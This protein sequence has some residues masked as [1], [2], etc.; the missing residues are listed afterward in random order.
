M[1]RL[2]LVDW[3]LWLTVIAFQAVLACWIRFRGHDRR[4]PSL[5]WF[6]TLETLA[7]LLLLGIRL[8]PLRNPNTPYFYTYWIGSAVCAVPEVWII[9]QIGQ[10]VL[11]ASPRFGRWIALGILVA[12]VA[13][14][15]G[16]L[17]LA[18]PAH[19]SF[20]WAITNLVVEIHRATQLAWLATFLTVAFVCDFLGLGWRRHA[21][22][23]SIGFCIQACGEALAGWMLGTIG[24]VNLISNINELIYVL[25]L[26]TWGFT[27][28]TSEPIEISEADASEIHSTLSIYLAA[29]KGAISK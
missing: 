18:R 5:F 9:V 21:L 2:T 11:A 24:N 12:S 7:N 4:W 23:I 8:A 14:F 27:L 6:L 26:A 3:G 29:V 28:R 17:T 25:A 20:P 13:Y 22:G 10:T 16:T 1:P 15:A 19:A